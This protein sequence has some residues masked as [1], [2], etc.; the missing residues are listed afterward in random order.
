MKSTLIRT[1]LV[2]VFALVASSAFGYQFFMTITG[3]TQ[4]KFKGENS[5]GQIP[6]YGY[7]FDVTTPIDASTGQASGKRQ[8]QPLVI[9]KNLD[10]ATP[11]FLKALITDEVL[12]KVVIQAYRTSRDGK[13]SAAFT[14]TLT[15]A[16]V[17]SVGQQAN[18]DEL[19]TEQVSLTFQSIVV[20][21]ADITTQDDWNAVTP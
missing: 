16:L 3:A 11:E 1:A 20:S 9:T 8:Y 4:G 21:D 13:I 14:I 6:I 7:S 10:L 18:P 19:Q 17:V 2:A 15:D 5:K 12:S